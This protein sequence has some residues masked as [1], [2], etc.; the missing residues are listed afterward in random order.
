M[1]QTT[2][3]RL[4]SRISFRFDRF[5]PDRFLRLVRRRAEY[6]K[7]LSL[8][9]INLDTRM[10]SN[11][12]FS[13]LF[14]SVSHSLVPSISSSFAHGR[15]F[16]GVDRLWYVYVPWACFSNYAKYNI[17]FRFELFA[18]PPHPLL[19]SAHLAVWISF[20][21]TTISNIYRLNKCDV[22]ICRQ[23]FD[24]VPLLLLLLLLL[25]CCYGAVLSTAKCQMM[26][27][28][29]HIWGIY[30]HVREY[31]IYVCAWQIIIHAWLKQ[32]EAPSPDVWILAH[33]FAYGIYWY[34]SK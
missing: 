19:C 28:N 26:K 24:A 14:V 13:V 27:W 11:L 1:T 5:I 9:E 3:I 2:T 10:F 7:S 8:H 20:E 34:G 18:M 15:W 4:S 21:M 23:L 22:W 32:W 25:K 6:C 33:V 16:V 17:N 12:M 31:I 29:G 30:I